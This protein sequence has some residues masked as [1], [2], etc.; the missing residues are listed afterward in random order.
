MHDMLK[1]ALIAAAAIAILN[2]LGATRAL[3]AT[4]A[5]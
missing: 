4:D 2:R 3:L 1:T 5:A